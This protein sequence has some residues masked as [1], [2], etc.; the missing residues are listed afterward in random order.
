MYSSS[1]PRLYPHCATAPHS[2][3]LVR[4][5]PS[6]S[7]ELSQHA[8]IQR[9]SP[10]PRH[11][12]MQ[13]T[14]TRARLYTCRGV[15]LIHP[16]HHGPPPSP[17]VSAFSILAATPSTTTIAVSA[18]VVAVGQIDGCGGAIGVRQDCLPTHIAA[19]QTTGSA[20][21]CTAAIVAHGKQENGCWLTY[22]TSVPNRATRYFSSFACSNR[23]SELNRLAIS[24]WSALHFASVSLKGFACPGSWRKT[25]TERRWQQNE[26][27]SM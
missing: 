6:K 9:T 25:L 1:P 21:A 5:C 18:A 22:A 26:R 19:Y 12:C 15:S 16:I 8:S 13:H 4:V 17:P 3:V 2:N 7:I 23:K 11:V 20:T 10:L 27:R 24:Y 14:H